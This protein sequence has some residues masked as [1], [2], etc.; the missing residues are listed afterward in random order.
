MTKNCVII[1]YGLAMG[2]CV[3]ARFAQAGYTV[4]ILS[5]NKQKL[6]TVQE[7]Y[8][9]KGNNVVPYACDLTHPETL[10]A[11]YDQI[12]QDLGEISVVVYN[13][14]D[15]GLGMY[16]ATPARVADG[17]AVNIT[18]LHVSFN[19]FLQKWKNAERPGRF[20]V[21]GGGFEAN[22]AYSVSFGLQFG[23]AAKSYYK[24]FA[25]S[26]DATFKSQNIRT[27]CVTVA[28]LVFGGVNVT[29]D[30]PDPEANGKFREKI[31]NFFVDMAERNEESFVPEIVCAP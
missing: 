20:L 22:G 30:D 9:K 26:A 4:A 8:A 11:V 27:C 18:S 10:S 5:R 15:F 24:N 31:G 23:S 13:G 21:T 16:D 3:L 7:E 6:E 19:H 1:G 28:S 12:Q 14:A 29:M 17:V 2:E 25:Q